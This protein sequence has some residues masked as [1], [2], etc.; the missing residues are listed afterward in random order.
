M[1][2]AAAV[3]IFVAARRPFLD[4]LEAIGRRRSLEAPAI[5]SAYAEATALLDRLLLAFIDAFSHT[6]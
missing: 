2:V 3:S 4:Q 5:T 1:D 6:T